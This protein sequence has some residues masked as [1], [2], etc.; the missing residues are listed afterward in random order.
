MKHEIKILTPLRGLAAIIV[1]LF[2]ARISYL[3]NL[4]PTINEIT[5]LIKLGYLWVDL[6]FILSGFVMVYVYQHY[7]TKGS[8]IKFFLLRLAR[9][10]PLYILTV[11]TLLIW[12]WFKLH[13]NIGFYGGPFFEQFG[14]NGAP[15][16][17]VMS[18]LDKLISHLF[19][20]QSLGD[21]AI[22]WN[23]AGW[24]LSA[25]W[26]SYLCFPFLLSLFLDGKKRYTF[27]LLLPFLV[28]FSLAHQHGNIDLTGNINGFIRGLAGFTIGMLLFKGKLWQ[29]T[30]F[31][32]DWLLLFA[33][34]LPFL[35]IQTDPTGFMQVVVLMSFALLIV[36]AAAQKDR[37]SKLITL[38]DNRLTRHLGDISFSLYLWH[39][40]LFFISMQYLYH[41]HQELILNWFQV[42]D[43]T[44]LSLFS[45]SLMLVLLF[46]ASLS[47]RFIEKP[48]Q[49]WLNRIN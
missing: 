49:H 35:L 7:F 26:L 45:I 48:A 22:T 38:I 21:A 31:K 37:D 15:A 46:I 5:P 40:P 36:V 3:Y 23:I 10:Y 32:N 25:E 17:A 30:I 4:T 27:Y 18:P 47:Y 1:V 6:F 43:I 12:G 29:L 41:Y 13:N 8:S 42:T 20:L 24:S 33:L 34:I 19:L 28:L 39:I 14:A 11:F 9:I 16:F 2:H 44:L